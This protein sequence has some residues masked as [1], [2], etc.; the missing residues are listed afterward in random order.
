MINIF[1]LFYGNGHDFLGYSC[2]PQTSH[3]K[4]N[5]FHT[6]QN[7]LV[8]YRIDPSLHKVLALDKYPLLTH[9]VF[10]KNF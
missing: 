8:Q 3:H 1:T 7:F 10:D 2:P 6:Y 4:H 9:S 5:S